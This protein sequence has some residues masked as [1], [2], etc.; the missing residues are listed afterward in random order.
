MLK[1]ILSV[2]LKAL[3]GLAVFYLILGFV[4]IPLGVFFGG[5]IIGKKVLNHPVQIRSVF[6]NPLTLSFSIRGLAIQDQ[7]VQETLVGFDRF[8]ADI[9]VLGFLKKKIHI[10]DLSL[11]GLL[12]HAVLLSDGT[13]NLMALAPA[14]DQ[15]EGE[16]KDQ[17][18]PEVPDE[19]S[20][21]EGPAA[22]PASAT[23]MSL[24]LIEVDRI[25]LT[26]GRIAFTDETMTPAFSTP[27]HGIDVAITGFSTRPDA[28]TRVAF[29]ALLDEKGKLSMETQVKP[30][31]QP[32]EAEMTF[33]INDYALTVLR[34]YVGKYTGRDLSDG[35]F[36]LRLDYRISNN[37]LNAGHKI[38]VQ[39]FT[40]GEKVDSPDALNLPWGL[41]I[42]LLEDPQG[43]I[44]FSVPAKGD[45]NSPEFDYFRLIG[46]VFRNFFMKLVTKPFS[47]LASIAGI[48]TDTGTD[49]LGYVRF[50]PGEAGVREEE[51][52]RLGTLIKGLKERP[53]LKLEIN[54]TY[55][56][57]TDWTAIKTAALEKEVADLTAESLKEEGEIYQLIYQRRFG[58]R[59]LWALAKKH[60]QKVGVYDDPAFIAAVKKQLIEDA[61]P[62]TSALKPLAQ[63][64]AEKVLALVLEQ[65][66]D[67]ARVRTGETREVTASM[68]EVPL[69]FTLTLFEETP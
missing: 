12:V 30:L 16:E 27:L 33:S 59:D 15:K 22:A 37:T 32:L 24:P 47:M 9:S 41:A 44:S 48:D 54:G 38:L 8:H 29:Q 46:Q 10:E 1:K 43:R 14:Q 36:D 50:S 35:K 20:L 25:A 62:D 49:D 19:T 2:F 18:K 39:K 56:P 34:P 60:K 53:R 57:V 64:R 63:E 7:K 3:A 31:A 66:M 52:Q 4:I 23:T 69:E 11:D 42:A 5:P 45:L 51:A 13:I 26:N 40:F 17:P 28:V 67:P 61:P 68:G 55:D 58:I 21:Q 65:G 6:F